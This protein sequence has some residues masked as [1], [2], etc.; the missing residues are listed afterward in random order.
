MATEDIKEGA[1]IVSVP[2]DSVLLAESLSACASAVVEL[3]LRTVRRLLRKRRRLAIANGGGRGREEEEEEEEEEERTDNGEPRLQREALVVAVTCELALGKE[4]KYYPFGV[5]RES[6][7]FPIV[8]SRGRKP[9]RNVS[10]GRIVGRVQIVRG[11]GEQRGAVSD[12]VT[13]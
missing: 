2:D 13:L 5:M 7:N 8:C 10:E 12:P 1:I 4:S 3:N 9:R 6:K 11:R